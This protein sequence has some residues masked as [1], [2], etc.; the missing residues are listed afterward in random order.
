MSRKRYPG[1]VTSFPPVVTYCAQR[2]RGL[3]KEWTLGTALSLGSK[4]NN[5]RAESLILSGIRSGGTFCLRKG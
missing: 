1:N 3:V 5:L 2:S 4:G